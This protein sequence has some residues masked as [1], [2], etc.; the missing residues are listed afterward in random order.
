VAGVAG[1]IT[2]ITAG[3]YKGALVFETANN[4]APAEVARF[5][6]TG[7]LGIGTTTPNAKLE[8]DGSSGSTL[9][10]VDGNQG[11]N[12]VLTSDST[13][14]ASWQS[15]ATSGTV[16][17]VASGTGLVAGTITT[18]GTINVDVGTTANKIVQLTVNAQLPAVDGFLLS[19]I[20]ATSV[21][22][23]PLALTSGTVSAPTYSF[24]S[25]TG[26]GWWRPGAG[27]L[28]ASTVGS[29]RMRIDAS[30]NVGVGTTTP[31]YNLEV[32]GGG[33]SIVARLNSANTSAT[34]LD[35]N[36][37]STGA[38]EWYIG[39][40]GS[41]SG[42]GV[43]KLAIYD[44]TATA[45]RLTIDA[46]GNVGIGTTAPYAVLTLKGGGV[47]YPGNLNIQRPDTLDTWGMVIG[48]DN[49]LYY[50]YA[51]NASGADASGD[52]T[53]EVV[54]KSTGIV[55]FAQYGAG[56]LTTDGGGNITAISDERLK[57]IQSDYKASLEQ[58][59]QINPIVYKWKPVSGLDT[60]NEYIGFSAQNLRDAL[61]GS[62]FSKK[63]Y[64]DADGKHVQ[65]N[66]KSVISK[67]SDAKDISPALPDGV[68]EKESLSMS[69][70]AITAALVNAVKELS[71]KNDALEA[72]IHA[73]ENP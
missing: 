60:E 50:G 26:T 23:G 48:G 30:G 38:H 42:F 62:V 16:T 22:G 12:K 13:G 10:I 6:N 18:S 54:F 68:T 44:A 66:G 20:N 58:L 57:D 64:L 35:I 47:N 51:T 55:Q 72:R 7:E 63:V 45:N 15:P 53:N 27:L 40:T 65:V 29:E 33:T 25:D 17:S 39:A 5:D 28:A 41:A 67:V 3:A 46:S 43:G 32:T 69:D 4:A 70:R 9:R 37:S 2:D 52:F 36:N 24:A 11:A 19:N 14:Q 34:Y 73:L 31:N 49:N 61:P 21:H 8:V 71:D 59:K 1:I 56:T